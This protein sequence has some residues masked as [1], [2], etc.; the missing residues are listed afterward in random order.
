GWTAT[1]WRARSASR[2]LPPDSSL[3][4]VT[5]TRAPAACQRRRAFLGTS[6]S[7]RISKRWRPC[8]KISRGRQNELRTD[9]G[10]RKTCLGSE[11]TELLV[12]ERCRWRQSPP[13][14]GREEIAD[15]DVELTREQRYQ[16]VAF[17][18]RQP[19]A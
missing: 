11:P 8:S 1:R 7:R 6:S 10:V 19:Q 16:R 4:L 9:P 14:F 15:A 2:T 18:R 12:P 5:V 13:R 17:G 3:S